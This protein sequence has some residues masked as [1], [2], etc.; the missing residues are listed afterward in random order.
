[1]SNEKTGWLFA[2][3]S[4]SIACEEMPR[5]D[6]YSRK[7]DTGGQMSLRIMSG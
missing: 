2:N 5:C 7:L 3:Q 4:S 6:H 1:M